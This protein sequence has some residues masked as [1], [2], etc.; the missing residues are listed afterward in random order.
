MREE[1]KKMSDEVYNLINDHSGFV[2]VDCEK[3]TSNT[4]FKLRQKLNASG[5][6]MK[7]VQSKMFKLNFSK[8]HSSVS[9]LSFSNQMAVVL[10]NEDVIATLKDVHAFAKEESYPKIKGVFMDN[11]YYN[12]KDVEYLSKLPGKQELQAQFLGLLDAVPSA[13]VGCMDSIVAAVPRCLENKA[14]E[15]N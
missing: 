4:A 15:N 12:E 2:F 13:I 8:I 3:L 14:K 5:N 1:K 11:T 10:T 6:K 9:E 7:T